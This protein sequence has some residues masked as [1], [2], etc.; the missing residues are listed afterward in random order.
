[1]VSIIRSQKLIDY[2]FALQKM[3]SLVEG[4]QTGEVD[5]ALWFVEH[6]PIYTFGTSAQSSE[7]LAENT[8]P[9]YRTGRG[10]RFTYHGPGQRVVYVM[11]DLRL[12][13]QDIRDFVQKLQQWVLISLENHGLKS[14]THSDRIGVWVAPRLNPQLKNLDQEKKIA[15]IGIRVR[16]WV[17]F[18]GM[19]INVCPDLQHFE[20]IIPCGIKDFGVTSFRDLGYDVTLDDLDETLIRNFQKVF[21][22]DIVHRSDL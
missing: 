12:R 18:H 3:E 19:A 17:S 10:G 1:M 11:L 21:Q 13:G 22:S 9:V 20:G 2:P 16:K 7:L 6:P 14:S 8:F 4:I 5:E 15:A